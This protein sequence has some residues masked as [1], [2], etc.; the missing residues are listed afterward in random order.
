MKKL[1][2]GPFVGEFGWELFCWQGVIRA[3]SEQYDYTT[4]V[5]R[6]GQQILYEDFAN[7]ILEYSPQ[8]YEPD[9]AHNING[10]TNDFPTPETTIEGTD[11]YIGPNTAVIGYNSAEDQF[12]PP[13]IQKYIKYGIK[14][15]NN[16]KID[17][18][19][20]A[21]N[22]NKHNTGYRNWDKSKW[23]Q[24]VE[25]LSLKGFIVGSMGTLSSSL[26]IE[27]TIDLRG[28][29]LKDLTNYLHNSKFVIGPSS[30][31]L[32]LGALCGTDVIVWSGDKNNTNRYLTS[33]NP[34]KVNVNYDHTSWDPHVNA[35]LNLIKTNELIKDGKQ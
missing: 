2:A 13:Y 21:R 15:S 6:P 19:I 29:S 27:N 16:P 8:V 25:Y 1:F 3:L 18:I 30:G 23:E 10:I 5:C 20:H 24:V 34:H 9:C 31:P 26:H 7:E 4:I 17:V 22:T 33:W 35:V 14:N 12:N 11:L 28:I 32:H